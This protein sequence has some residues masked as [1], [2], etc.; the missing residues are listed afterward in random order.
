MKLEKE[1]FYEYVDYIDRA[2]RSR[3]GR[4]VYYI[5]DLGEITWICRDRIL[6]TIRYVEKDDEIEIVKIE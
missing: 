4:Y 2:V 5:D 3:Y 1:T 6:L